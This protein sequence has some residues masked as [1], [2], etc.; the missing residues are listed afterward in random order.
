MV[1][2][3]GCIFDK[4]CSQLRRDI[5]NQLKTILWERRLLLIVIYFTYR[6]PIIQ[7][8]VLLSCYYRLSASRHT[9]SLPARTRKICVYLL[10][11]LCIIP[12]PL[13]FK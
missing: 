13:R 8:V 4:K 3:R 5:G 2:G 9:Y 10:W 1:D 6:I 12:S 7:V 11:I